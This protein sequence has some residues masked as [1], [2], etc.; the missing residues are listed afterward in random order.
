MIIDNFKARH[1]KILFETMS[2]TE[3]GANEIL[4]YEYRMNGIEALRARM[5]E[6]ESYY[7]DK[8]QESTEARVT[9]E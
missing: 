9:L 3:T 6:M 7:R 4:E 8:K 2:F 1:E 5:A